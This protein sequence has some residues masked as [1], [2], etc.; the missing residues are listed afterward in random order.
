[1]RVILGNRHAIQSLDNGVTFE[2]MPKGKRAT[3]IDVPDELTLG[4][5]FTVITA[6]QG[7]WAHQ[8]EDG[9][10]PAWVASESAGL[11]SLLAEHFG[12]I[13]IRTIDE[14]N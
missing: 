12:D 8:A 4:E 5:A 14:E 11:S 9:A 10:V 6:R 3:T 1:M 13:E 2:A 7:V